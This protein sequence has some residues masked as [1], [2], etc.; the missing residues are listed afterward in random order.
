MRTLSFS[1]PLSPAAFFPAFTDTPL[2]NRRLRKAISNNEAFRCVVV[3]P[4]PEEVGRWAVPTLLRELRTVCTL[5]EKLESEFP[6][7]AVWRYLAFYQLRNYAILN[8]RAITDQVLYFL[9]FTSSITHSRTISL[10]RSSF[11][12]K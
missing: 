5:I 7:V 3:F 10:K 11:I 6:T 1:F 12:P 2:E 8:S 4:Q 9:P